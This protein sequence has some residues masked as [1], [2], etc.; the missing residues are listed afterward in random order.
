MLDAGDSVCYVGDHRHA[1]ANPG[2]T[3]C[4]YYLAMELGQQ[5]MHARRAVD[6]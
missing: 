6:G 3:D 2:M 4:G 5:S 1:F